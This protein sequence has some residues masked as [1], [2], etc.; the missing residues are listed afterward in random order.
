MK[1]DIDTKRL[2]MLIGFASLLFSILLWRLVQLQIFQG[3]RFLE[4]SEGNRVRAVEIDPVR[5]KVYD[6]QGNLLVDNR[7]SFSVFIIPFEFRKHPQSVEFVANLLKLEIKDIN[8]KIAQHHSQPFQPVRIAR[9]VD[10]VNIAALE[11]RMSEHPG[12]QIRIET[13][14]HYPVSIA[15]HVFGYIGELSKENPR[16]FPGVKAGDIVGKTGLELKYDQVLRG[17]KGVRYIQID[18]LGRELGE[19][20]QEKAVAPVPGDDIYLTLDLHLMMFADSLL[21]DSAGSVVALDPWSGEIYV[22]LSKPRYHPDVFSGVLSSETWNQL[23]E[24][25]GKPLLHRAIQS[26]YPPGSALKMAILAAGLEYGTINKNFTIQC[27]G[28]FRLGRRTYQCWK[29]EGHGTVGVLKSIRESC[30]VFFYKL[31]LEVG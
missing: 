16:K 28:S 5:G 17:K 1:N 29:P 2:W 12:L 18:A 24:D 26:G 4:V 21:A 10:F 13:K 27:P 19:V 22:L 20:Y 23:Q 7:P 31:G 11:E 15:P 14:R 6:R 8:E 3:D 9:D 30:D 25:P